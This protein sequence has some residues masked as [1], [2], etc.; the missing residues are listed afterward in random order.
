MKSNQLS[1]PHHDD[2]KTIENLEY[3]LTTAPQNKDTK[4]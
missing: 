4:Q 1:L 3:T 2:C